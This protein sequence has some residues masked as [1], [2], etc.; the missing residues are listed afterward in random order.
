[1]TVDLMFPPLVTSLDSV[2]VRVEHVGESELPARLLLQYD[3]PSVRVLRDPRNTTVQIEVPDL[4]DAA[5]AVILSNLKATGAEA[6]RPG[7]RTATVNTG[8]AIHAIGLLL[9]RA[10]LTK[11]DGRQ[12]REEAGRPVL[13]SRS[14]AGACALP[15]Y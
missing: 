9:P 4:D 15:A 3:F 14:V 7:R 2:A 10:L 6:T 13:P 5:L 11:S 12:A 1:M 8:T